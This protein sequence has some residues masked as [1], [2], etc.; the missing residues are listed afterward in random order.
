MDLTLFSCI[1][2]LARGCVCACVVKNEV[3]CRPTFPNMH[4]SARGSVRIF[5]W[6]DAGRGGCLAI[7]PSIVSPTCRVQSCRWRL[8]TGGP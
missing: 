6:G 1:P 4:R 2:S 7:F 3:G 5:P 8:L